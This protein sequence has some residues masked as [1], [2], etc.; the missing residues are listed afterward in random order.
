M[1]KLTSFLAAI[2][3]SFSTFGTDLNDT[4][5]ARRLLRSLSGDIADLLGLEDYEAGI[6]RRLRP[7]VYRRLGQWDDRNA[8]WNFTGAAAL[9]R[10][11]LVDR[12][13]RAC[14]VPFNR[15]YNREVNFQCP[16]LAERAVRRVKGEAQAVGYTLRRTVTG[17]SSVPVA[18]GCV[19]VG[20]TENV[21]LDL[22]ADF[23]E[24]AEVRLEIAVE[25]NAR[26]TGATNILSS[27][28][29]SGSLARRRV[30][31]FVGYHVLFEESLAATA[32]LSSF[33]G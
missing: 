2:A 25:Q 26:Y 9:D 19:Q 5:T 20:D 18:T 1:T 10:A 21:S 13:T 29:V 22:P 8:R 32:S 16:S 28:N 27:L 12:L 6:R 24:T 7:A 4:Q 31:N 11:T 3:F 17:S 15:N 14:A 23:G 30:R 33:W